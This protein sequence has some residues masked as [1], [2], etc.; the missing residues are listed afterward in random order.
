MRSFAALSKIRT[1]YGFP[2]LGGVWQTMT[3]NRL[4]RRVIMNDKK[5]VNDLR[6]SLTDQCNWSCGD[7]KSFERPDYTRPGGDN[8]GQKYSCSRLCCTLSSRTILIINSPGKPSR[9]HG[10]PVR[11]HGPTRAQPGYAGRE[12]VSERVNCSHENA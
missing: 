3:P 4:C 2:I 9:R 7:G 5:P 10:I 8:S 6:I 11:S 12:T 1:R